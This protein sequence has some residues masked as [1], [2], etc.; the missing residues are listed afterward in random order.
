MM[1]TMWFLL[2]AIG[3]VYSIF[4]GTLEEI[5]NIIIKEAGE[6]VTFAI[7][8]IGIMSFWLGIMNIAK[9]SGFLEKLSKIF[10]PIMR[11]LFP[12]IPKNHPAEGF[13]LM[14]IIANMFG[15]G[16]GATAF[17]LKAMEEINKL[18]KDKKRA[19]NAMCMFLVI[20]MSSVQLVPLTVLKIR[21][22]TGSADPTGIVGPGIIATSISTIVGIIAV[23]LFEKSDCL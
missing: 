19:T 23:K 12:G 18:N 14:N 13:I 17:G 7:S 11:F 21:Y 20:N 22:D 1:S 9:E 3:I 10:S 6:A 5:N 4:A 16:N 2:I 15:V 8:L